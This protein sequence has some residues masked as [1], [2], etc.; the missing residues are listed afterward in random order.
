[1]LIIFIADYAETSIPISEQNVRAS[2]NIKVLNAEEIDG[3]RK[4]C[5]VQ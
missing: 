5:K 4:V 3:M 1:M 2:S